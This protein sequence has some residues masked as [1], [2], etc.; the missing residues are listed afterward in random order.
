MAHT[1]A[2][3]CHFADASALLQQRAGN[4]C[5]SKQDTFDCEK[6]QLPQLWQWSGLYLRCPPQIPPRMRVL[7]N[8]DIWY[9]VFFLFKHLFQ[10]KVKNQG[11]VH[12]SVSVQRQFIHHDFDLLIVRNSS[13]SAEDCRT[14]DAFTL[15]WVCALVVWQGESHLVI[16]L[17]RYHEGT[18]LF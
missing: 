5:K 6:R 7:S 11:R 13:F 10:L 1:H 17:V 2:H 12:F 3:T 9:S 18:L 15:Q 16:M 8:T 4:M 14:P